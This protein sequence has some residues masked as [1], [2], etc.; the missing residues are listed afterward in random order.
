MRQKPRSLA[1]ESDT[2]VFH[3]IAAIGDLQYLSHILL[4]DQD[5][6][7]LFANR[8]DRTKHITHNFR[9]KTKRWFI[10]Y[11]DARSR[12]QSAAPF[13]WTAPAAAILEKLARLSHRISGTEH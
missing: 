2:T 9:S 11:K 7:T 5:R 6:S 10:Q 13:V 8:L 1:S 3:D 12:H 4:D